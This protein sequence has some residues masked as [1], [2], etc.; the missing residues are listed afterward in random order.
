MNISLV[1]LLS[2]YLYVIIYLVSYILINIDFCILVFIFIYLVSNI[3]KNIDF[4]GCKM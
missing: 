2:K 3:L 4:C 1:Y